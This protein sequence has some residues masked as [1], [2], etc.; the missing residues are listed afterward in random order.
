MAS[1]VFSGTFKDSNG[2]EFDLTVWD[3]GDQKNPKKR[4]LVIVKKLKGKP[5]EVV[6]I[7]FNPATI[8]EPEKKEKDKPFNISCMG[9]GA[10]G[11]C[12]FTVTKPAVKGKV[13]VELKISNVPFT[14]EMDEAEADRLLKAFPK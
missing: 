7:Y 2:N 3:E 13:K 12:G 11:D 1:Q 10:Q 6:L 9:S 8:K 4:E 5:P 14:G